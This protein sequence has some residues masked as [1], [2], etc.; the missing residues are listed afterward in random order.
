[1]TQNSDTLNYWKEPPAKIYRKFYIFNVTNPIDVASR[2]KRPILTECG[3]YVYREEVIKTNVKFLTGNQIS[4]QPKS[5]LYFEPSLSNGTEKDKFNFLD[6]PS[7][8]G[9]DKL[10]QMNLSQFGIFFIKPSMK[11]FLYKNVSDIISGFI[12]YSFITFHL[13]DS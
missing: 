2:G 8:A 5:T 9:V 6:V 11:M 3:P 1:M 12:I 13:T 10:A 7:V 4:Y